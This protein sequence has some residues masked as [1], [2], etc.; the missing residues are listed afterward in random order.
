M[1]LSEDFMI[2]SF[3]RELNT[4]NISQLIID[5]GYQCNN[6][7]ELVS[8]PKTKTYEVDSDVGKLTPTNKTKPSNEKEIIL[9]L[10]K[11]AKRNV[12]FIYPQK[13]DKSKELRITF[14]NAK[15]LLGE[16][17]LK[18]QKKN[19]A[20]PKIIDRLKSDLNLKKPPKRIEA[21]ALLDKPSRREI[22][23]K[24]RWVGFEIPDEFVVG[25]GIDYAQ[26]NRNLSYIGKV[27]FKES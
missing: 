20:I 8:K 26:R 22:D 17:L 21:C 15:L 6:N 3:N 18:R 25:Y 7:F 5:S 1:I 10:G 4:N 12:S 19:N 27:K 11:K 9:W 23:I 16:W 14:Q 24:S 2:N 13:G